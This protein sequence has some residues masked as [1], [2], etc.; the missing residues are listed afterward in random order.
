[1]IMTNNEI[2]KA[3]GQCVNRGKG[4]IYCENCPYYNT[5]CCEEHLMVDAYLLI[6]HQ[7]AEIERLQRLGASAT[8]RMVKARAEAIKEF[9]ERLRKELSLIKKECRK[10]LD[11]G[12][13]FAIE[14]A[15]KKVDNLVKEMAGDS[16][17]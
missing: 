11:N 12:G 16:D 8:R 9:A 2:I 3:L 17:V 5:I 4:M 13:V 6:Q 14:I 7:Q 1:M 15:R 10:F